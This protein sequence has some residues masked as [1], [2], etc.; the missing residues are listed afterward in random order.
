MNTPKK[1]WTHIAEDYVAMCWAADKDMP[2]FIDIYDYLLREA[3]LWWAK[4]MFHPG[5]E[6]TVQQKRLVRYLS[7]VAVKVYDRK[8]YLFP[9][10]SKV[11]ENIQ[12]DNED[13]DESFRESNYG[14]TKG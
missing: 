13:I 10:K 9:P 6:L 11:S 5:Q 2:H 12:V 8:K 3:G 7:D 14:T 4:T 1:R